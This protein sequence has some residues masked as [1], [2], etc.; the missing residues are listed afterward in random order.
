MIDLHV[1]K[2]GSYNHSQLVINWELK[3]PNRAR[4]VWLD[5]RNLQ[6][7]LLL[8]LQEIEVRLV[9]MSVET[10][11]KVK[12]CDGFGE[13][14]STHLYLIKIG[15]IELKAKQLERTC[16]IILKSII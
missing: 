1:R 7:S 12:V 10:I 3:C 14:P 2:P 4:A 8:D 11:E 16:V 15:P 13:Y 5:D 9:S 6:K